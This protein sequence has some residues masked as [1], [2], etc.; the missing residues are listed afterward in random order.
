MFLRCMAQIPL[1]KNYL[2]LFTTYNPASMAALPPR[3]EGGALPRRSASVATDSVV[4]STLPRDPEPHPEHITAYG[5]L[6]RITFVPAPVRARSRANAADVSKTSSP[7]SSIH[8]GFHLSDDHKVAYSS[9]ATAVQ[10]DLSSCSWCLS[11]ISFKS[12]ACLARSRGSNTAL[13]PC[14]SC[15]PVGPGRKAL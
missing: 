2:C 6:H 4:G 7:G 3:A 14:L 10:I 5:P 8:S 1:L 15:T 13:T 9:L 11:Q 12:Q